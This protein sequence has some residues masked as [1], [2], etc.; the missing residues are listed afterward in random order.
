MTRRRCDSTLLAGV[1][2]LGFVLGVGTSAR[3]Q[4]VAEPSSFTVA[5]EQHETATRTLALTNT[6]SESL[7][8]CLSF[9]RPLQRTGGSARISEQALGGACGPYGEVLALVDESAI[10]ALSWNPYGLA[11]TP[12]G[13]LFA[14]ERFNA[15][16]LTY[17]LTPSLEFVRSFPHPVVEEL[18]N[19]ALTTGVAYDA[20]TGT[21]WWL[22]IEGGSFSVIRALL[23][24]GDLDGVATGRRIEIPVA[25]DA[26]PPSE[27]GF[28]SGLGYDEGEHHFFFTD[29]AHDDIW[30]VD[31][32]GNVVE[33]YP[34]QMEA[35]PGASLGR[36]LNVLPAAAASESEGLRLEL[37]LSPTGPPPPRIGVVGRHGE[38]TAPGAE[39]LETPFASDNPNVPPGVVSG[40][41]LRSVLDPNGVLYYPWGTFDDAGIVAIRPHP[42]PPSWLVVEAWLGGLAPGESREVELTFRPGG[43]AVGEYTAVLQAFEAESGAAV[44]VPLTLTVTAGTDAEDEAVTPD[45]GVSLAV[46]PNPVGAFARSTVAVA[47]AEAADV[48]VAV[49]D[50]LGRRVAVL[51]EGPLAAG[52]HRFAFDSASLPAGVYLIRIESGDLRLTQR[53]TVLR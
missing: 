31:T 48:R 32:L 17:E 51:H 19:S 43:R 26:P 10:E 47:L 25:E 23:V 29:V 52:A 41:A 13:R 30:A 7:A 45:A 1:L 22:N 44:E 37:T 50:V 21:L 34:V 35:Y 27:T 16:N 28:P 6:G 33:G 38:D 36:G 14:A 39:P 12:D 3:A 53:I 24:E 20:A 40:E 4:L 11:M 8:F 42:L 5:V 2:A 15:T 9:D 49:Y 18:D 46:Y